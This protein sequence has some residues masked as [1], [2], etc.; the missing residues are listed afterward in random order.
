MEQLGTIKIGD[1]LYYKLIVERI[2]LGI[3][4]S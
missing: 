3:G 2:G 1:I 4:K